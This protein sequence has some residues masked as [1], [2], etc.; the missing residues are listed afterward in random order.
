MTNYQSLQALCTYLNISKNRIKKDLDFNRSIIKGRKGYIYVQDGYFVVVE[1]VSKKRFTWIKNK[2]LAFME[3]ARVIIDDQ[4][5]SD[6]KASFSGEFRLN[7]MPTD[8]E[9]KA[10]RRVLQIRERRVLS[11]E[12]KQAVRD[13]FRKP[14]TTE[15]KNKTEGA[16][17][18]QG[19]NAD[20]LALQCASGG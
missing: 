12:Q 4:P 13:R 18:S 1:N 3:L 15:E 17:N 6:T 11:E 19:K 20:S 9:A 10:I 8:K 16:L 5:L 7:R 2:H 14:T